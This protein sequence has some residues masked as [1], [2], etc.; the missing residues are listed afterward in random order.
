MYYINLIATN[1]MVIKACHYILFQL[2]EIIVNNVLFMLCYLNLHTLFIVTLKWQHI[3][4]K[5]VAK[6]S[7]NCSWESFW[8]IRDSP[9]TGHIQSSI[10][11]LLCAKCI[12]TPL[13][14]PTNFYFGCAWK[15][16]SFIIQL[17]SLDY[18]HLMIIS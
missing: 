12:T 6:L 10:I 1:A 17:L 9:S 7:R 2:Y 18:F 3:C 8:A 15:T 16:N 4:I 14:Y 11:Q 13:R 5:H